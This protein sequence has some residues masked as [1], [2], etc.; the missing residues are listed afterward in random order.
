MKLNKVALLCA[1]S[2]STLSL[3]AQAEIS[4]T[5]NTDS[6]GTGYIASSPCSSQIGD[7]GIIK[8]HGGLKVPEVAIEYY[9]GI[10]TCEAHVYATQDCSGKEIAT[11]TVDFYNGVTHI[12]NLDSEHF[13][14]SGGGNQ[15][16]IDPGSKSWLE[17][18]F[19]WL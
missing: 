1:L 16:V 4:V 17:R 18:L 7:R 15:V 3:S 9:C 8:P 11:L 14:V 12:N 13:V 2:F 10:F 19:K 6:Y 5:N